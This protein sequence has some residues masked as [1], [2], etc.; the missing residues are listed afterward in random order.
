M[1]AFLRKR[2]PRYKAYL[3]Q[4]AAAAAK[5]KPKPT[6]GASTPRPSTYLEQDWQRTHV[7]DAELDWV[8]AEGTEDPEVYEC[9]AC[10]KSFKSEAAWDSHERSKKHLK[11][12]EMLKLEMEVEEEE[13]GLEQEQELGD[14][15]ALEE[16]FVSGDESDNGAAGHVDEDVKPDPVAELPRSPMPQEETP[17]SPTPI[18]E[19]T[20]DNTLPLEDIHG[21]EPKAKK[22]RRKQKTVGP[23]EEPLT[24]T[25]QLE[26]ERQEQESLQIETPNELSKRDKRRA[27]EAAKKAQ[28]PT[29]PE[30]VRPRTLIS[31]SVLTMPQ[32]CNVCKES[33]GSRT[34]LFN[35]VKDSGHALAEPAPEG[36]RSKG[37]KGKR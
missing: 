26:L 17:S 1:V 5:P 34:K 16:D 35:H 4:Q 37:K 10:G 24:K 7:I 31:T 21:L 19:A 11:A 32:Q 25:A 2:D 3:A 20:P 29:E 15:E 33:F 23:M 14:V 22:S 9:V 8:V 36:G 30:L 12:V 28:V 27:R 6:S 13:L 18:P